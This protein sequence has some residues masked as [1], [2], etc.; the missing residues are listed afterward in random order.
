MYFCQSLALSLVVCLYVFHLLRFLRICWFF[1]RSVGLVCLLA[2]FL[3]EKKILF[4]SEEEKKWK[5]I[6]LSVFK[7]GNRL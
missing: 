7:M 2:F 3:F 1:F 6:S 5:E 4:P